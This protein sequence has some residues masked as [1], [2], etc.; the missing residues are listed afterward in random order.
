MKSLVR[1]ATI[2]VLSIELMCALTFAGASLWHEWQV[3]QRAVDVSLHGR[4][5]SL[6]GAVQDAEDP[7]DQ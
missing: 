6:I 3:R 4:T 2:T 1:Q 7:Q 5:D